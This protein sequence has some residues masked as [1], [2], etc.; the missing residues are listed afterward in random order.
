[1]NNVKGG[2]HREEALIG[3]GSCLCLL[4]VF[5]CSGMILWLDNWVSFSF[6]VNFHKF[7]TSAQ[8]APGG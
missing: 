6:H 5:Y 8:K 2:I 3:K 1:M 4:L 7:W